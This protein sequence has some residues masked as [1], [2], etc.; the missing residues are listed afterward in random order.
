MHPILIE[1]LTKLIEVLAALAV[2]GIGIAGT[3]L[4]GKLAQ[5][6]QFQNV[7]DAVGL[8]TAAAQQTVQELQ[9]TVVDDLKSG[10]KLTEEQVDILKTQLVTMAEA[11]VSPAIIKLIE[12]AGIDVTAVIQGA[13]E[14]MIWQMK[15]TQPPALI[16]E[17]VAVQEPLG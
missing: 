5:K 1:V 2:T 11:K 13:G 6:K 14:S 8:L 4:L 9:Q 17:T 3:W 10:G 15:A 7:A 16:E 12:A